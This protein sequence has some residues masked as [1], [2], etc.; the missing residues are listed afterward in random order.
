MGTV[1]VFIIPILYGSEHCVSLSVAMLSNLTVSKP[2]FMDQIY[3]EIIE[4]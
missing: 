1:P 2:V 4:M 3:L